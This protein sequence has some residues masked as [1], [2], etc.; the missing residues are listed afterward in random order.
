VREIQ[1]RLAAKA[2]LEQ[3]SRRLAE[4]WPFRTIGH[5]S[6]VG[7]KGT[8]D[9]GRDGSTPEAN[10]RIVTLSYDYLRIP[11]PADFVRGISVWSLIPPHVFSKTRRGWIFLSP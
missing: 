3:A 5:S 11:P 7:I 1:L 9:K 6:T 8:G 10:A 4:S 2:W